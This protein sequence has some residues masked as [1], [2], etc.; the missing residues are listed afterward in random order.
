[1]LHTLLEEATLTI[2]PNNKCF[3]I[4]LPGELPDSEPSS[5][6]EVHLPE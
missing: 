4:S 6:L 2:T 1:M 3:G 5:L